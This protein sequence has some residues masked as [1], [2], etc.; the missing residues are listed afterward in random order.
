M[1]TRRLHVHNKMKLKV[2]EIMK[3]MSVFKGGIKSVA[4]ENMLPGQSNKHGS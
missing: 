1:D 4:K 3:W 2:L